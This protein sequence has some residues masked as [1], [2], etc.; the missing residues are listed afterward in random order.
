MAWAIVFLAIVIALI[1]RPKW[2][3]WALGATAVVFGLVVGGIALMD[4]YDA[5]KI[6]AERAAIKMSVVYAPDRCGKD[7][8]YVKYGTDAAGN[9]V[10]LTADGK[11]E[12]IKDGMKDGVR[13][14]DLFPLEHTISNTS[15]KTLLKVSWRLGVYERGR[16]T[17]L[18]KYSS[19]QSFDSDHILKPGESI[20]L[21]FEVPELEGAFTDILGPTLFYKIEEINS[22]IFQ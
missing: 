13:V 6:K 1:F 17:N 7:I 22:A 18:V 2:T 15:D 9:R 11:I 21:C 12:S 5:E 10:G 19:I 20:K 8:A 16:S 4:Y 3:L 14:G